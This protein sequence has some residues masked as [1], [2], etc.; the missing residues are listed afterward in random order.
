[1]GGL[2]D[3]RVVSVQVVATSSPPDALEVVV[4][5]AREEA[6]EAIAHLDHTLGKAA[7]KRT[8]VRDDQHRMWAAPD[9]VLEP[10]QCLDIQVVGRLVEQQQVWLADEQRCQ[11]QAGIAAVRSTRAPGTQPFRNPGTARSPYDR[12]TAG[13]ASDI[14]PSPV[15]S[16]RSRKMC[17][18]TPPMPGFQQ[19]ALVACAR[20]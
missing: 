14:H 12:R 20:D 2:A 5:A 15:C 4:V 18:P 9:K 7:Q 10:C 17:W 16:G 13:S 1:M 8:V 11:S 19:S 3:R 6:H